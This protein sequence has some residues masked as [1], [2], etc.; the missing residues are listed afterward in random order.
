MDQNDLMNVD[1]PAKEHGMIPDNQTQNMNASDISVGEA[2]SA[3][4][5]SKA[6]VIAG[7]VLFMTFVV[8]SWEQVGLVYVSGLI[9]EDFGVGL[10]QVGT[11]LAAVAL[12]MVPGALLWAI[13]VEKRGRKFVSIA[14]LLLYCVLALVAAFSTSFELFVALRFLSGVAFGGVY[15]VTF[16]YFMELLPT[17]Y[18]GQG[19]VALSIGFPIGMLLC[20]AVSQSFGDISW[21]V[22]AGVAALAGLWAIAV[23][24]WVPES[25]Y[26]LV[27]KGREIEA[28]A[29]LKDFGVE[30]PDGRRLVLDAPPG[31][32]IGIRKMKTLP[33]MT[34][35]I[36]ISFAFSWAYWGLQSWLPILLQDKGL[37]V[38]G[39]LG[40][41][42][43]SQLVAIPG[44]IVAAWATRR[45]GR[46]WIFVI[47]A[48]FSGI[49]ALLFGASTGNTQLYIGNFVLAF[50]AL[51]AWGIWNTWS[52]E[53]MPTKIRGAGYS[54]STSAILLAQAVSVPVVGLMMDKGLSTILTMGSLVAFMIIAVI[55]TF[56]LPE[57]EG[58]E[59]Q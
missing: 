50:F 59:L 8:E 49:G 42:A 39:S 11:A 27:K 46:R 3:M 29:V 18:R 41:V 31:D 37:S 9:S 22:V 43:V 23:W 2:F 38:S 45:F 30:I 55:A 53:V 56:G 19:A 5:L 26:W 15:A 24:K 20:I 47:F 35:V 36:V 13:V 4:K 48:V 7:L 54:A 34:L 10:A 21:R 51:G 25:P 17:K 33:L 44:Y 28:R 32:S 52:G 1:P 16:P 6:H 14:S 58:R 57:T 40:F 12:G